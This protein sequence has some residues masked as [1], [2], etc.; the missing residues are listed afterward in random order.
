VTWRGTPE[1]EQVT[2]AQPPW[3]DDEQANACAGGEEVVTEETMLRLERLIPASPEQVFD[4]WVQPELLVKW[5]GPEGYT[6]PSPEVDVREGGRWRTVMIDSK[7]GEFIV[8]G[9]YRSIQRPRRLVF[10]WTWERQNDTPVAQPHET[11]ITVTFE[12]APGGGTKLVFVQQRFATTETRNRHSH[13]WNS[14]FNRLE[15]LAGSLRTHP[16]NTLA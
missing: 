8:G 2:L 12:P 4:A 3:I 16:A 14:M 1:C 11:E 5:W 10:T 7:G 13:G 9:V 15:Q 6:T